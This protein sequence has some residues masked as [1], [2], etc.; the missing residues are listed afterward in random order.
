[1][2][3]GRRGEPVGL[4]V[5]PTLDKEAVELEEAAN[6]TVDYKSLWVMN[7]VADGEDSR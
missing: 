1:V 2:S 4:D 5:V 3:A 7:A 6:Y